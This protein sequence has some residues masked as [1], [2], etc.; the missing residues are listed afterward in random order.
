MFKIT[1]LAALLVAGS[2]NAATFVVPANSIIF[3]AGLSTL[4][5]LPGGGGSLPPELAVVAGST[6]T[7]SAFGDVTP[8]VGSGLNTHAD[9]FATNPVAGSSVVTNPTGDGVG[10]YLGTRSFGLLGTFTGG[11]VSRAVFNIGSSFQIVVPTGATELYFGFAD[12]YALTG[13]AS[14]YNDNGGFVTVTS[15]ATPEPGTWALMMIGVGLA[16]AALRRRRTAV[17]A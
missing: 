6:L 11:A 14:Y 10:D 3:A 16:G 8:A 17:V 4:P 13:P 7:I 15:S 5:A 9:G 12:G 2:V 1:A